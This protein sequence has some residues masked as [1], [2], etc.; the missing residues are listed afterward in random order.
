MSTLHTVNKS[1]FATQTLMS[2]LNH[3]RDGDAVLMI[4][5]GVYGALDRS[6]MADFVRAKAAQVSIYVLTPD[7][8]ARGLAEDKLLNDVQGIDYAG[9]VNL[10]TEHDRTQSWL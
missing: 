10:V 8:Q 2:C 9:F 1:P 4:E 3:C 7:A 5:D 6:G